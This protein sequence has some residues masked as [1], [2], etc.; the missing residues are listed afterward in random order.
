MNQRDNFARRQAEMTAN[1][2]ENVKKTHGDV[3]QYIKLRHEAYM[4]RWREAMRFVPDGSCILDVG[5]GN[6]FRSLVEYIKSKHLDY[7]YL[8]IDPGAVEGSRAL[9]SELGLAA[10]QANHGFNDKFSFRE[11]KF[12]AV[13]SSHC[14]EHSIDLPSTFRELNRI[15]K[16]GGH[17]LMAVPFGWEENPEHP[18]F[19]DPDQ[20]IALVEDAGFEIRVAQIGREYPETGC[21]FFVAA[22]KVMPAIDNPRIIAGLYQKENYNFTDFRDSSVSY[23]G[24]YSVA[25]NGCAM[26]MR[27]ADWQISVSSTVGMNEFLPVFYRHDWSGQVSVENEVGNTMSTDLNSWFSYIGVSRIQSDGPNM[28]GK[29][30]IKCNGR[31][32]S[33]RSTEGVFYGYMWR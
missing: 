6:L 3:D 16:T 32:A 2:Y 9:L 22:K 28:F 30:I 12:D 25:D 27:G 29:A 11:D 8:D 20:W 21:D 17:L 19:F 24:N 4:G 14:I 10:S 15:I 5:G 26:H 31:N 18:Y 7:H 13:F 33:S 23:F 1:W